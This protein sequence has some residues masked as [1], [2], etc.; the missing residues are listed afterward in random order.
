MA[1]QAVT[2]GRRVGSQNW[3]LIHG[4]EKPVHEH[5]A[6]LRK[7][8]QS[9]R[10]DTWDEI[11]IWEEHCGLSRKQRFNIKSI[12]TTPATAPA[13]EKKQRTKY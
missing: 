5:G 4:P 13:T 6:T 1:S 11:K 9:E 12:S 3:E 2:I 7:L 10:N 8:S